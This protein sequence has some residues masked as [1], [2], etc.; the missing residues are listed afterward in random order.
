MSFDP[1][2]RMFRYPALVLMFL[3]SASL[4]ASAASDEPRRSCRIVFLAAPD[5]APESLHLFDGEKSQPVD[6]PRLG[7]SEV[8]ALPAGDIHI[9]LLPKAVQTVTPGKPSP[10]PAGAPTAAI[11]AAMTDFYLLLSSD[12]ANSVAPVKI[13]VIDA[14][15]AQF[16]RGQQLWFNLTPNQVGGILG[17]Q[18]V[19]F[20]PNSRSIVDGPASSG[21]GYQ[22][23]LYHLPPGK[24]QT[25]PICETQWI[26]DPTARSVFFILMPTNK[27][28]PH[29]F[30]MFDART[31]KADRNARASESE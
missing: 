24:K 18:K 15:P 11:P 16:K 7:L 20:E 9:A 27:R 5:G 19:R 21:G 28:T 31:G 2:S 29:V 8:Y 3:A 6:L 4:S 12:P 30:G 1:I 13:Q 17:S 26:Y 23:N 10:V 14:N 22:V 25:Y